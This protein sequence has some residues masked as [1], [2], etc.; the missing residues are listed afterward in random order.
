LGGEEAGDVEV[1]IG[2]EDEALRKAEPPRARGDEG[3]DE[4]P[5]R[6]V[7]PQHLGGAVAGDVEVAIGAEDEALRT[8]EPPEPAATKALMKAPVVPLYRSTWAVLKLAT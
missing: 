8:E 4:G 6:A 3:V 5:R 1:A 2:A 7:V